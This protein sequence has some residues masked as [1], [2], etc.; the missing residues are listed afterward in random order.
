MI[1]TMW[2]IFASREGLFESE[3]TTNGKKLKQ[4]ISFKVHRA[5]KASGNIEDFVLLLKDRRAFSETGETPKD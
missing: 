3:K 4:K 5:S 2:V 1:A